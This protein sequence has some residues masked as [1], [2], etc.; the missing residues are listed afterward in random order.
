MNKSKLVSAL[1]LTSSV[2]SASALANVDFSKV[3]SSVG[4]EADT[5]LI[6]W[7]INYK[8]M[9][10][11]NIGFKV[12]YHHSFDL[13][14]N[15]TIATT[16]ANKIITDLESSGPSFSLV[17]QYPLKHGFSLYGTAGLTYFHIDHALLTTSTNSIAHYKREEFG[18]AL[19][20]GVEWRYQML[21]VNLGYGYNNND[22]FS[23][24]G[25]VL[26]ANFHF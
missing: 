26:G 10:T 14:K 16:E 23:S 5:N 17:G 12:A 19:S 11:P 13:V 15:A 8:A 20:A 22:F 6:G 25:I 1:I 24:S 21:S 4:I 18:T 3:K 2:F 7:N 9:V